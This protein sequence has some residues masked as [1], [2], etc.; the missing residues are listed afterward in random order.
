[1]PLSPGSSDAVIGRNIRE[2]QAGGHPHAQAVA[3]AL[4]E[5]GKAKKY[6]AGETTPLTP[7]DAIKANKDDPSKDDPSQFEPYQH[8]D[9]E[10]QFHQAIAAKPHENNNLAVYADWLEENGKPGFGS[11][12]RAV[13]GTKYPLVDG[14]SVSDQ[15]LFTSPSMHESVN[16]VGV[17]S[18]IGLV[19]YQNAAHG[20]HTFFQYRVHLPKDQGDAL[21]R[22]MADNGVRVRGVSRP[23]EEYVSNLLP[24]RDPEQYAAR[25]ARAVKRVVRY[26]HEAFAKQIALNP[27]E[28]THRAVYA[29]WLEENDPGAASPRTLNFLRTHQGPAGVRKFPSGRVHAWEIPDREKAEQDLYQNGYGVEYGLHGDLHSGPGGHYAVAQIDRDDDLGHTNEHPPLYDIFHYEPD[30]GSFGPQAFRQRQYYFNPAEA[31]EVADQL[32]NIEPNPSAER[33]HNVEFQARARR[34]A[35]YRAPAGGMVARGTAYKGGE[36][37][38]D[39]DGP[40][41][42]PPAQAASK[43]H[44]EKLSAARARWDARKRKVPPPKTVSDFTPE[45][46]TGGMPVVSYARAVAKDLRL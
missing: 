35:A 10:A 9:P 11:F 8:G 1:M 16:V 28:S 46:E 18:N 22:H 43:F 37:V 32:A 39:M 14:T 6:A 2:M 12:L 41:M 31:H 4:R 42:N 45:V 7:A 38:P 15:G 40:Y 17:G 34:Y 3:A 44:P 20:P 36:M 30:F 24:P 29:D 27:S 5:A 26:S 21:I 23:I 13:A 19:G 33:E 25:M